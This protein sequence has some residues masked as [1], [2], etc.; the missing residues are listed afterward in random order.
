MEENVPELQPQ[1]QPMKAEVDVKPG[2]TLKIETGVEKFEEPAQRE[3]M[4]P[5]SKPHGAHPNWS[6]LRPM[7]TYSL[8]LHDV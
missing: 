8:R 2:Y 5:A 3:H 7:T 6:F 4:A 1:E